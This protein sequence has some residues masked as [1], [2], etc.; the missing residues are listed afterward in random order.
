MADD[1]TA[2]QGPEPAGST[3]IRRITVADPEFDALYAEILQP[4]DVGG[5]T[6]CAALPE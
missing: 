4:A 3:V 6:G 1:R 5:V 2:A